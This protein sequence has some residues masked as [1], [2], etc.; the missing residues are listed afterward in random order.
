MKRPKYI[1]KQCGRVNLDTM[2]N[3]TGSYSCLIDFMLRILFLLGVAF[4]EV[5]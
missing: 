5:A 4:E 2:S 3:D 1:L